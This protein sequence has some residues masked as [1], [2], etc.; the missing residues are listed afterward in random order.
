M[1]SLFD[2]FLIKKDSQ[3]NGQAFVMR[4]LSTQTQDQWHYSKKIKIEK[5]LRTIKIVFIIRVIQKNNQIS[6]E[7]I[8]ELFD[9]KKNVTKNSS[10][11]CLPAPSFLSTS[12][13]NPFKIVYDLGI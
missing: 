10:F 2:H 11:W 13:L 9:P 8:K 3:I 7:I 6:I 12:T 1:F 4:C 5:K